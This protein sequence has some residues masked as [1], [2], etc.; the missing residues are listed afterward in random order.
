MKKLCNIVLH[1]IN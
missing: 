1:N